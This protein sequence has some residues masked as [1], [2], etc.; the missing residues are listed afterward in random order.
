[1]T[2][3]K[4]IQPVNKEINPEYSLE[5]LMLKLKLKLQYFGHL[6]QRTDSLE[7]TLMLG[8]IED[9]RRKWWQMVR[10]HHWFNAHEFEQAPGDGEGQGSLGFCRLWGGVAESW[11]QLRDWTS[12]TR[13]TSASVII[14]RT[15]PREAAAPGR[16]RNLWKPQMYCAAGSPHQQTWSLK[17]SCHKHLSVKSQ[18]IICT[19]VKMII[20]VCCKLQRFWSGLWQK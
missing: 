2:H 11:T 1:M 4:E 9:R 17:Q 3:C 7:N 19:S 8:K 20:N 15:F 14:L 6:M 13:G 18:S 5:G 16:M 12:T 10:W